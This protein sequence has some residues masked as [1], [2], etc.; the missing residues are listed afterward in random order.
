MTKH[1]KPGAWF[2]N[3]GGAPQPEKPDTK[4]LTKSYRDWGEELETD[5]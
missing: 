4:L 3:V 5:K 2:W 1:G